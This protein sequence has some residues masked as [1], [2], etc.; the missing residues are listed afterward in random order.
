MLSNDKPLVS[1][2]IPVY[3]VEKYLKPCVTSVLLQTYKNIEVLLI[4]DGSTD[5]SGIICDNYSTCDSRV[6][7]FHKV[8]GGVS[9]ARNFGLS[10]SKG[11]YICFVDSDDVVEEAMIE[12]ML[13]N[14][15]KYDSDISCCQL[16]VIEIDGTLRSLAKGKCG[17]YNK[18][19][20]ISLY[21]TD[22][23]IKDQMYGPVNKLFKR[24]V[25]ENKTFKQY[26]LGEDILFIFEV[27]LDCN[28]IYISDYVGY[29][30]KHREGS[31]MTSFFSNKRLDYIYA[32]QEVVGLCQQY[33]SYAQI[34]AE[35]WLFTHL[36][37]TI[38]QIIMN[39][40][41]DEYIS[42]Y[43]Q[44]KLLLKTKK[45][46]LSNINL[47]RKIDYY[48]IL[49]FPFYFKILKLFKH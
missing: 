36:I 47:P 24:E 23:F 6:S 37:V 5:N 16:T 48:A 43:N 3:N 11:K 39:N 19:E 28:K 4:D 15:I 25:I 2:I 31:A 10:K 7:V 30:Y 41:R 40:L 9:S 33:V 35:S 8:N 27:L 13:H 26:R 45:K 29:Y 42:F 21:F 12:N 38:R 22:Q 49:Y 18:K 17:L 46:Y 1:I 20:V 32:C 14:A 44:G 34:S